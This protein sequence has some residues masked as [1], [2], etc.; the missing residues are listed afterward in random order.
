MTDCLSASPPQNRSFHIAKG[1]TASKWIINGS[2]QMPTLCELPS[3]LGA[4]WKARTRHSPTAFASCGLTPVSAHAYTQVVLCVDHKENGK[5][6]Q[7]LKVG[8]NCAVVQG[9]EYEVR[10]AKVEKADIDCSNGIIHVIDSVMIP[11]ALA[12]AL[13]LCAP[14]RAVFVC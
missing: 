12:H 2:G 11:G 5:N 10:G 6:G 8:Q 9:L 3:T 14:P 7:P 1:K 4:P 13:F